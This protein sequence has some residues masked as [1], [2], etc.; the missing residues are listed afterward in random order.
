MLTV[1]LKIALRNIVRNKTFSFINIMGLSIGLVSFLGIS[2]YVIDELSYDRFHKNSDRIYRAIISKTDSDGQISKWGSV[3]NKLAPTAAK[4]IPEVEK[5][6]RVFHHNFGDIG[7]VSTETEK[8]SETK[9]FFADPEIFDVFTI[10]LVKGT[11]GKVLDRAGTVILSETSAQRYFG[12]ADPIGKSLLIDN[13]LSLEVT[14]VYKDFPQNSFLKCQLI[15]SFSS[16]GFGKEENQRWG[17]ASFETYF[18][19]NKEVSL[20]TANQ[21]IAELLERNIPKDNRWFSITLQPLLDIRLHSTDL[22]ASIDRK[23]YGD[24][25][26]V[27]VLTALALVILFIAAINYMNLTTAQAQRRNKEVGISKTLGAIFT[28]L[29]SKFFLET[30]IFVLTSLLISNIVFLMGLPL[31]NALSGKAISIDFIF[32]DWFWFSFAAVWTMLTLLSGFYPAFYLSSFSPKTTLLKTPGSGGQ[33]FVRKGLV[34]FQFS[35]SIVLIIC[36]VMFYKQMNF[37]RNKNLGYQPDQVIAVMVSAAKDRDQVL[38]LKTE[39]ESLAEVKEVARSQSYPGIGTSSYTITRDGAGQGTSILTTRATHEIVDV[40]GMKLL[41]GRTLPENKDPKDTTIQVV[42]NKS[43]ADYLQLTPD[44]AVGRRVRIFD[45]GVSE[46][47]GVVDDFH[48]ASFHQQIGPYCFNNSPD[49]RY[50]YLLV[51]VQANELSATVK[52]IESTFKKI[53]PAAFEFTFLDQQMDQLYA[54]DERLA[55][56]VL[57]FASLAIIIA[58]LGLYALASFTAEQRTREIGIRKILG[59]SVTDLVAMLSKEFVLLVL[60]AFAIGVPIGYYLMNNWLQSF[61]Y[62]TNLDVVIFVL[63][64]VISLAIAW[65]TVSFESLRAARRN[66]VESLKGE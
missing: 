5:V 16:I 20:A 13:S 40:L 18:L 60:I 59:A 12:D 31:F 53:I 36:A 55:N 49:N 58:C 24:Y 56:I 43:T 41:A 52:K 17:N 14:G 7:F 27:K 8:F 65:G 66:P 15:A 64:G 3:P 45:R 32:Q 37:M 34:I 25:S 23:Q 54:S 50:I 19:L 39:L 62:K 33:A 38:S 22:T 28:E 47:V 29:N 1:Y 48:F 2:L 11:L 44:E 63:A 46:I 57:L 6:T 4:E 51:K 9:L 61:A 10:P 21:K 35:I 30:S 26:Q 42:I